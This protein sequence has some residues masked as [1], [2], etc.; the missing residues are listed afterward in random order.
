MVR[1]CSHDVGIAKVH[2]YAN[3]GV[4]KQPAIVVWDIDRIS[5]KILMYLSALIFKQQKMQLMNMEGVE[6]L[7]TIFNN[8]ILDCS[9]LGHYIRDCRVHIEHF[10][11]LTFFGQIKLNRT[12]RV[13]RIGQLLREIQPPYTHWGYIS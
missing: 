6:F 8:P 9:L 11:R 4:A 10:W 2:T 13:I 12:G 7:G 1:K 3:T 5:Q